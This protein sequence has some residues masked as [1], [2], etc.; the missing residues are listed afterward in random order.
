MIMFTGGTTGV[1][2]MVPW[3]RDN[4]AG[5]VAAI[6][7]GYELGP[8][9]ATVAV[10]P[11]YH[12][13]GLLAALLSTL[14]SGGSGVAARAWKVLGAHVLGRHRRRRGHLVHGRPDDPSD[15]V[16]ARP[17]RARRAARAA[18]RFIRS[19]SAPLTAETAQAL[20]DTFSA[21]VV[22]AFGMTESTHQVAT[23]AIGGAGHSENPGCHTGSRRPL[24]RTRKSGSPGRTASRCPLRPSARS[25][26]AAPPWCA[27]T[28]ATRRSPPPTSP[29]AGCAPVTWARCRR[30]A[31][32]SSAAGSRNSS[33]AAA[34]RS[35]R[36]A[37]RACW[38][39][40]P[41]CWRWPCSACRTSCTARRWPR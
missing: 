18:L 20:H 10:M 3:T 17:N 14:A 33:T 29:R 35:R 9:D 41:T 22:C 37:S 36:S 4:I 7:A 28:S 40:T 25:G 23:T 26:C 21:P 12:G 13:H 2:K 11:L 5:S 31:T 24:D 15:S 39:A 8:Q 19:C 6:I 38:P 30:P 27:A 32:S 34:R 1:P 16:G